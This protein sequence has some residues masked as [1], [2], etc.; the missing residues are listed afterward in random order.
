MSPILVPVVPSRTETH[1][2]YIHIIIR[3]LRRNCSAHQV[4][5]SGTKVRN[6]VSLKVS[7][8]CQVSPSITS[9]V[10]SLISP[11]ATRLS[12]Y[13]PIILACSGG[14][15]TFVVTCGAASTCHPGGKNFHSSPSLCRVL[16]AVSNGNTGRVK[17]SLGDLTNSWCA[18][19]GPEV[20]SVS[21]AEC[22]LRIDDR[23][24]SLGLVAK[25]RLE[26][27]YI[28]KSCRC[29]PRHP[30]L[31]IRGYGRLPFMAPI[32]WRLQTTSQATVNPPAAGS[33]PAVFSTRGS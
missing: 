1:Q 8:D 3:S 24:K 12:P 13:C 9:S 20:G 19:S 18:S 10:M 28:E 6:E 30:E 14:R 33:N 23:K 16:C 11:G 27:H 29:C 2:V 32:Q 22:G 26:R 25:N 17:C 7:L 15:K 5:P 21:E 4:A 31:P